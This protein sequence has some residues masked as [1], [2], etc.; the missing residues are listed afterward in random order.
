MSKIVFTMCYMDH[1]PLK[2]TMGK[3]NNH[4]FIPD[5]NPSIRINLAT[6]HTHKFILIFLENIYSRLETIKNI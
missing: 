6:S 1:I 2:G 3:I 4:L 5:K